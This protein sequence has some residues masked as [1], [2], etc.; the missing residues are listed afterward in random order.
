MKIEWTSQTKITHRLEEQQIKRVSL[1]N[2]TIVRWFVTD[3]RFPLSVTS[4]LANLN[5]T[6]GSNGETWTKKTVEQN[7][8]TMCENACLLGRLLRS[9][10]YQWMIAQSMRSNTTKSAEKK[11]R[12]KETVIRVR[13]HVHAL[14]PQSHWCGFLLPS[15]RLIAITSSR[16]AI[17]RADST[18]LAMRNWK[19]YLLLLCCFFSLLFF[20]S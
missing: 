18:Q 9:H 5:K 6:D 15:I 11:R 3:K 17:L 10:K 2:W 4:S 14:P 16:L 19:C 7:Y 13:A 1:V 12:R 20:L 8:N